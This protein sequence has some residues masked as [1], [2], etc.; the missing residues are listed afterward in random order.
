[1]REDGQYGKAAKALNSAGVAEI[2]A[3]AISRLQELHPVSTLLADSHVVENGSIVIDFKMVQ[4]VL[5]TFP[6]GTSCGASGFR[7]QHVI[8]MIGTHAKYL[9]PDL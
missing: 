1:M 4:D 6:K 7:V 2:D 5:R 3:I 8:D 9:S